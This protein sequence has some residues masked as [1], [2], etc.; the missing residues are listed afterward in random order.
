MTALSVIVP[1]Y[2]SSRFIE[3]AVRCLKNQNIKDI[4]FILVD[5][6]STDRTKESLELLTRDDKRFEIISNK[7]NLGYGY[8]VNKGIKRAGSEYIGIF[9]PDDWIPN[10][11]YSELLENKGAEVV[12]YNGIYKQAN[13]GKC[14]QLFHYYNH[15]LEIF[16]VREY[17]KYWVSH[18]SITNAIYKREFLLRN[19]VEFCTGGGASYQDVQFNISLY[20]ANP[21]IK[22]V[23]KC[24]Y[25]YL[26]NQ[27]QSV[28]NLT[29]I[30]LSQVFENWI[31]ESQKKRDLPSEEYFQ[32]SLYRHLLK[33]Y[34]IGNPI[35]KKKIFNFYLT[36]EQE[37]KKRLPLFRYKNFNIKGIDFICLLIVRS[38][39][40]TKQF[41]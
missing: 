29:V 13:N 6:G 20:N 16:R 26:E 28:K 23:D 19:K 38:I 12:K 15:P 36:Q 7:K 33:L 4:K 35:I 24:K 1:F 9:E 31:Q 30:K 22:I 21:T 34:K 3:K 37:N 25:Y 10:D 11:F 18:P 27:Q 2:N 5:D 41:F 17:Q 40:W 39:I 14:T 32:I 8:S